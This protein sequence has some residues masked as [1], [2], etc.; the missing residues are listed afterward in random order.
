[1]EG[2]VLV[3]LSDM[4]IDK[5]D[6]NANSITDLLTTMF[7]EGGKRTSHKKPY[8]RP[9]ILF[10]NLRST[11]GF[12]ALSFTENVSMV[13]G[14]SPML[15]NN[16]CIEGISSLDKFTPWSILTEQLKNERFTWAWNA[17]K[18]TI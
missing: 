17:V 14:F 11:G 13:S 4:Q 8:K 15:L 9:K 18:N 16:F 1:M 10:W 3:I 2:I 5:A 7:E 12:P 6:S